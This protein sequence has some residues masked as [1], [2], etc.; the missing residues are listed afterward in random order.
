MA[1]QTLKVTGWF[2]AVTYDSHSY[3]NTDIKMV[4]KISDTPWV[5]LSGK[6]NTIF[7]L[8]CGFAALQKHNQMLVS[9]IPSERVK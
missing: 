7:F 8:S 9:H 4:K 6:Y 1:T 2:L 5:Y 3:A